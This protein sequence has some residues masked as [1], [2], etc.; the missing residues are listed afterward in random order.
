M[1]EASSQ[2]ALGKMENKQ[3]SQDVIVSVDLTD[4]TARPN[5]VYRMEGALC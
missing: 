4:V 1:Y 3:I 5:I 2:P